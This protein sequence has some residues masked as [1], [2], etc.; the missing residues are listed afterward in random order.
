MSAIELRRVATH[1][2]K[3]FNLR[4]DHRKIHV[5]TG[6]SG[7]GKSSLAFDTL[8]AEGQRR[9]MESLSSYARQ[10]LEK[11]P[12]PDI[13]SATGIPPAVAIQAK[14]VISNARSTVGTQ[15]EVNDYL[16]ALFSRIG[17][18]TC[19]DC[20][21]APVMSYQVD[22]VMSRMMQ[23]SSERL[24]VFFP[25]TL[26]KNSKAE[27][28]ALSADFLK[29]GFEA[30]ILKDGKE[31]PITADSFFSKKENEIQVKVDT[32]ARSESH[33]NRLREALELA[34]Q[35]G[36]GRLGVICGSQTEWFSK[37]LQCSRCRKTFKKVTEN[38]FSF[39]SP[40][41]AC[42][43]CQ[44][45]GR[46]I[47]TDWNLVVP[48]ESKT[49]Q[50][51][52]VDPWTK[53][54]TRWEQ[55]QLLDFCKR[56]KISIKT[57][58]KDLDA[59]Q[60]KWIVSGK[61]GDEYV[62]VT[63]YFKYL[64]KKT[65][66][67]HIRI[68]LNRY[69]GYTVCP[70]CGGSRLRPEALHVKIGDKNFFEIQEMKIDA[71]LQF[72]KGLQLNSFEVERSEALMSEI[73]ARLGF[74][75]EVGLGYLSL[76]RMSRTLSGGEVERIHLASS[77]GASLTDTL[78][79][80]D[81]PSI[82]LHER[83]NHMLISLLRKLRDLGNTV[84][85]VEHD[86]AMIEAADEI[87]DMGPRGGEG[88]GRVLYQG[89]VAGLKNCAES[90]TGR[91]LSGKESIKRS[92]RSTAGKSR[93]IRIQGARAHNLKNC[94]VEIPLGKLVVLTG[95]SG[96]G[97]SSLLYEVLYNRYQKYRGR[98]ISQED[99]GEVRSIKGWEQI[100]DMVLIDQSPIGRSPRSNPATYMG[101]YD[102]IRKLFSRLPASKA[103]GLTPGH[104]SFNVDGGRCNVCKGDGQVKVEMHFLADIFI[105][106]EAC[107][108]KRFQKSILNIFFQGK[109]VDQILGMTVTEALAFFSQYSAVVKPLSILEK[110]GLGYLRLGQPT[111]TLSGG[112][113]QRLKL[114]SELASSQTVNQLYLF[115]EPTT[116]LHEHDICYLMQA[117]DELL[118]RGH[119]VL[120]IEHHMEL[121][122]LADWVIDLGPEGG[123]GGGQVVWQGE[124]A[125]LLKSASSHTGR[126]LEAYLKKTGLKILGQ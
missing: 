20:Q 32:V 15:T 59:Q 12:K 5:M 76:S 47:E 77:L 48:D 121:I 22:T 9:Y 1:N 85:V 4:L 44:G 71:L 38:S 14:N 87:V 92:P 91:Y 57:P 126:C 90:L 123:D 64:E 49:I 118:A 78:Y 33:R 73:L 102:E 95:V 86:R 30:L 7:S 34:F 110:T 2:L 41:G 113:G 125:G 42:P 25:Y 65:Y 82:G 62:S 80:L 84:V 88:G 117:F 98:P 35:A 66:K 75:S 54:S 8:Y 40:L 11:M 39:N 36:S 46:V 50:D 112:E 103:N 51:G 68:F 53:A 72:F 89:P 21:E 114:A 124:V 27:A 100:Q 109:N 56:R 116:G 29:Q 37:D 17:V 69:R 101:V 119:S 16:R 105:P 43:S 122:R 52:A 67:M 6:V 45:F 107:A 111:L 99:L 31:I 63:D 58:W 115:D 120:V 61:E 104:F 94:D 97:K 79:V 106:C 83:D 74:L 26:K 23:G 10:F 13:E 55:G 28:A 81:E 24:T 18:P 60:K 70:D 3:S 93:A 96:S 108:G 19:P